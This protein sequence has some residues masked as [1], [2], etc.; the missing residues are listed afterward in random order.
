MDSS[1][2]EC[3]ANRGS[4]DINHSFAKMSSRPKVDSQQTRLPHPSPTRLSTS[5]SERPH[6]LDEYVEQAQFKN[7]TVLYLAYAS[8][9]S[10][11]T[12]RGKRGIKPLAQINVQ[13]P[14][15]QVTFDLPGIPYLEPCFAN[16]GR[17]DPENDLPYSGGFDQLNDEKSSLLGPRARKG[18]YRKDEWRKGLIG[19][20]Y[21]VTAKD[22]AHIIATEGGGAAYQDIVVDCHPFASD[23]PSEPVPQTP[24]LPPFKAHTLFAPALPPNEPPP[25]DGGRVQRPNKSYAQASARYLKLM[26]DGAAELGLPYEYQDHL[27]SLRPYKITTV[28]QRIGQVAFLGLWAPIVACVFALG[29]IFTDDKGRIPGW[30]RQFNGAMFMSMWTSYDN[31]FRPLF[32]DGERSLTDGEDEGI[33]KDGVSGGDR[34]P[35]TEQLPSSELEKSAFAAQLV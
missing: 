5:L 16:S 17:R 23:D 7:E 13:A 4:A 31:V 8:N 21:E 14:S 2:P 11:E 20:V 6:N 33:H 1:T 32:G 34:R 25:D 15:L 27:H 10:N 18:G 9:L 12:F 29:K 24:T 28:R 19:V 35:L 3:V 30:L 26:T 22:Y